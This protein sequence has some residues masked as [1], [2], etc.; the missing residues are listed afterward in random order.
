MKKKTYVLTGLDEEFCELYRDFM[1][2]D[3]PVI[4]GENGI[5]L[6][7]YEELTWFQALMMKLRARRVSRTSQ[8]NFKV[9][10][11]SKFK[12]KMEL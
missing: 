12:Q 10:E 4:Q 1:D 2:E 6:L 11:L 3:L 9:I 7:L 8:Y 5:G